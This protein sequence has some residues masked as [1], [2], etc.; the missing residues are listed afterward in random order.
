MAPARRSGRP[1]SCDADGGRY[2]AR[3]AA[4]MP[5]RIFLSTVSDEFRAYRDQLRAD[6][7]RHTT[8]IRTNAD[9]VERY[10][11]ICSCQGVIIIA[12]AQ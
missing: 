2:I 4:P 9:I 11:S 6:L 5:V 7:T 3:G 10:E 12:F 8:E 1:D